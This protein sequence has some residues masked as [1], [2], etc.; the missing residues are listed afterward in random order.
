MRKLIGRYEMADSLPGLVPPARFQSL[1]NI[2][3]IVFIE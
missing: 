1:E 2:V 3:V